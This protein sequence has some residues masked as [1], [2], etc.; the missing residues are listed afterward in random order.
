[1]NNKNLR[2]VMLTGDHEEIAKNIS[3]ELKIREYYANLLPQ[4]K[5]EKVDKIIKDEPK[6][7]KTIF[8]GDGINDAPVIAKADIGVAMGGLGQDAAIEVADMVLMDDKV[9]KILEAI[10]ISK[11]TINIAKQNIVFAIL[12]KIIVL[13]LAAFG[14]AAMWLAVFADVGVTVL[15]V[16]NAMRTLKL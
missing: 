2:V 11:K 7:E 6:S 8:V 15:A 5:V 14:Y 4:D 10:K 16:L 9:S 12:V 1:M 3:E 13:I